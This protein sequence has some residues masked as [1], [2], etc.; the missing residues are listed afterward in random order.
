MATVPQN[1]QVFADAVAEATREAIVSLRGESRYVPCDSIPAD[2]RLD[3]DRRTSGCHVVV[4][5]GGYSRAEHGYGD[6]YRQTVD[7]SDNT[8]TL[9]RW[10]PAI[11]DPIVEVTV[12]AG[13]TADFAEVI[14]TATL[15]GKIHATSDW[16][17]VDGDVEALGAKFATQ[18]LHK[19]GE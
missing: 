11:Q 9:E 5:Y 14:M 4:S 15:D 7:R 16:L 13:R 8:V 19:R 3:E 17:R 10:Q 6:P 1:V 18:L 2:V 12:S